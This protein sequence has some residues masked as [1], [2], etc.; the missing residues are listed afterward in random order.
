LP[1]HI[2]GVLSLIALAI[3]CLARYSKRMQSGWLK[4]YVITAMISLYFNVFVLIAQ[5]F[6]KVPPLHALTT[7][8]SEPP[9]AV[10]QGLNLV[11][12]II[13]TTFSVKRFRGRLTLPLTGRSRCPSI[14]FT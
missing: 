3:A 4:T 7:T 6:M 9:F 10:A 2:L 13:L 1:S 11:L 12:F 14:P 5:A 8:G